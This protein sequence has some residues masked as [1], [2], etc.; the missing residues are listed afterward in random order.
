MRVWIAVG[1]AL[2][3][4]VSPTAWAAETDSGK[5]QGIREGAIVVYR[6]VPFAA[7]PVGKLRWRPPQPVKPWRGVRTA[8]RFAPACMQKGVSMPGEPQSPVSEDCLYLN[9]WAP[10]ETQGKLP[11]LV[12]IYGGGFTNGNASTPLY[13]GERLAQKGVIVVTV[14][15]RAG[16]FGFLAHPDLSRESTHGSSGNYGIMDQIAALQWV[17]RNIAAFGGD[18][19][20]ITIAGQSAGAMSVSILMASPAAKGLFQRAIGQ[21][22]AFFEPV[23]IAPGFVLKNAEREGR[24][25]ASSLGASSIADLRRLPAQTIL[26]G[27]LPSG[28]HPI[29]EPLVLPR[30]PF[31]VFSAGQQADVPVLIGVNAEEGRAF[32]D[33]QTIKASTFAADIK[34]RFGELPPPLLAPY[35]FGNDAEARRARI[36]F[37]TDLR[38]GWG[39]WAWARLHAAKGKA[40]YSYRFTHQP[41]YPPQSPYRDWG[42]G[43]FA[44]LWYVFDRLETTPWAW[45]ESDR[46]LAATITDY[47][48]NFVKSGT[49]NA[50]ALP[51]WPTFAADDGPVL[52]LQERIAVGHVDRL[53]ALRVFDTVYGQL[54]HQPIPTDPQ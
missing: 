2:L 6:G 13:S 35:P 8:D 14:A 19:G 12:W 49:P 31:D 33:G 51:A 4:L 38:F 17:R 21:S 29:V 28:A 37:E 7:P 47:W 20:R 41:P 53:D 43:H 25:F 36:D 52:L 27:R 23:Q 48:T 46:R 16:A 39:M 1:L 24:V 22:G 45:R 5:V 15:Y 40:V 18:P 50:A 11:V 9:I 44:E 10:T 34:A 30:P 3:A 26:N 54:R 32:L 42:A